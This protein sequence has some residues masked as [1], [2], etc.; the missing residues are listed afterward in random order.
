MNK[1]PLSVSIRFVA[2]GLR[3]HDQA[4]D[5]AHLPEV[6]IRFVAK[7]LRQR[8]GNSDE[9]LNSAEFLFALSRRVFVNLV[10]RRLCNS[11]LVSIRFVAKGLRQRISTA[12]L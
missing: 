4:D 3:Q 8:L 5:Y 12:G 10:R 2:K 7:G 6:S 1:S 9:R 11:R